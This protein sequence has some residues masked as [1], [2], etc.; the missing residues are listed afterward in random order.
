MG[1]RT[2][3]GNWAFL[4]YVCFGCQLEVSHCTVKMYSIRRWIFRPKVSNTFG[5]L[6]AESAI[7]NQLC[8]FMFAN[9]LSSDSLMHFCHD[10]CVHWTGLADSDTDTRTVTV[11]V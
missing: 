3:E 8:V 4:R 10:F 5:T 1:S 11:T 6:C 2:S 9:S 7:S